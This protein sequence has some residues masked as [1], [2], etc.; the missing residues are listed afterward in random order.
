MA[1]TDTTWYADIL[2]VHVKALAQNFPL[3][4][5]STVLRALV[6]AGPSTRPFGSTLSTAGILIATAQFGISPTTAQI[7]EALAILAA[8]NITE[9]VIGPQ[10][11]LYIRADY[12]VSPYADGVAI[13][14]FTLDPKVQIVR[15]PQGAPGAAGPKGDTGLTGPQ[16]LVGPTGPAGAAGSPAALSNAQPADIGSAT[17]GVSTLASRG[18]HVH[19]H[20]DQ[21][22]GTLHDVATT[23]DNGF[24]SAADKTKLDLYPANP[25][26]LTLD[27]GTLTGLTDD[28]HTQYLL[29]SGV[30]AMT[31]ALDMGAQAI[32]NV[33]N[34]DGVDVSTHGSRHAAAGA[35]PLQLAASSRILGRTTAGAGAVE[36]LTGAQVAT[37]INASLDH[38]TLTGLGDDDH[39]QYL[40]AS[41]ARSV[42]GHLLPDATGT[43]NLGAPTFQ[44]STVY[45]DALNA[46]LDLTFN[47]ASSTIF[48][49]LSGSAGNAQVRFNKGDGNNQTSLR[50][51]MGGVSQWLVQ[52]DTSEN[53]NLLDSAAGLVLRLRRAD[54][55][56]ES[57]GIRAIADSA[58]DL[59]T[60]TVRWANVYADSVDV[61]SAD[62]SPTIN[63]NKTA[64]GTTYLQYRQAVGADT[65]GDVRVG[66][67]ASEHFVVQRRASGSFADRLRLDPTVGWVAAV[68]VHSN[69][70][71]ESADA[72]ADDFVVGRT[73]QNDVGMTM[74]FGDGTTSRIVYCGTD[75]TVR[76]YCD[77]IQDDPAYFQ[78]GVDDGGGSLVDAFLMTAAAFQPVTNKGGSL[79]T[80]SARFQYAHMGAPSY[81]PSTEVTTGTYNLT[82]EGVVIVNPSGGAVNLQL[83]AATATTLGHTWMIELRDT[84]N[85]V[86]LLAAAG[87]TF[88]EGDTT[89][90]LTHVS[91][92]VGLYIVKVVAAD[93]Y[94]C[95]G[96]IARTIAGTT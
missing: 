51:D 65:D 26:L 50:W 81:D 93:T 69:G 41:G 92:G 48:L 68:P 63:L 35:D 17:S 75:S 78:W 91:N 1:I 83:P 57:R 45:A 55:N 58:H 72:S 13:S 94:S 25:S 60:T 14:D 2:D 33:G 34:V 64:T 39:T 38:G 22:G 28:D 86:D 88:Y 20:G 67:N 96:P 24:M 37:L 80:P 32:T 12:Q 47:G 87:D 59:G 36:E 73:T 40:L 52:H 79:G 30:R 9:R 43:R 53:W 18:D 6:L 29:V 56:I 71:G 44:W 3:D 61:G 31:G 8:R 82:D 70:G 74:F 27:H 54:S 23:D 4:F 90:R 85:Q 62:G 89:K 77:Y 21:L 7:N 46:D 11:N 10:R 76:A 49:G 95:H 66:F 84:A 16:G 5:T 42:A 15:G 19:A